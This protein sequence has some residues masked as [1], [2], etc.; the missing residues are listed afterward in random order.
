[1]TEQLKNTGERIIPEY[2]FD[3]KET[4]LLYLRH[5]FAYEFSKTKI[6]KESYVLEVGCGEGY[7]TNLLSQHVSKIIGLDVCK[8][9]IEHASEK[10][11]S[12]NLI[13]EKYDGTNIPYPDETF[14]VVISFQVIE[15]IQ[16]DLNYISET[17]RVLKKGGLF[18]CTT[19]NKSS[20]KLSTPFHVREYYPCELENI[21]KTKFSDVF[22]WGIRGN[23]EVQKIE[24]KRIKRGIIKISFD[25]FKKLIPKQIK[26]PLKIILQYKKNKSHKD[27][28]NKYGF[29]D[30]YIIK[31]NIEDCSL[32]LLGICKK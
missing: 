15:H 5:L 19:I 16:D 11:K 10:Y 1:M 23:E 29:R 13:F 28:I 27:F 32:D 8:D 9:T 18:I 24:K 7:G 30:Y 4:Y 31:E 6:S 14:D 26:Y 17:Y 2:Y 20:E 3:T 12:N 25:L 22:L 21:L